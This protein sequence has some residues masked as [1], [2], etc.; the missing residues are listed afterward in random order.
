MKLLEYDHLLIP[1]VDS[2]SYLHEARS[3]GNPAQSHSSRGSDK[4]MPVFLV[5]CLCQCVIRHILSAVGCHVMLLH[6]SA[7]PFRL[8]L[9]L[10][11]PWLWF[12]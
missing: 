11:I 7:M 12:C 4:R 5:R 6:L 1:I 10:M 2:L 3:L 8:L 9:R